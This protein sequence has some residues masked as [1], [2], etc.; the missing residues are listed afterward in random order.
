MSEVTELEIG[1]EVLQNNGGFS[2]TCDVPSSPFGDSDVSSVEGNEETAVMEVEYIRTTKVEQ[3]FGSKAIISLGKQATVGASDVFV[4][5]SHPFHHTSE[6]ASPQAISVNTFKHLE[7]NA[8]ST[9]NSVAGKH[10]GKRSDHQP[11]KQPRSSFALLEERSAGTALRP[12][13]ASLDQDGRS[14][15]RAALMHSLLLSTSV[16]PIS[17]V[18]PVCRSSKESRQGQRYIPVETTFYVD[19]VLNRNEMELLWLGEESMC[20]LYRTE[21]DFDFVWEYASESLRMELRKFSP[22]SSENQ[23]IMQIVRTE[24]IIIGKRFTILRE[25]VR[26]ALGKGFRRPMMKSVIADLRLQQRDSKLKVFPPLKP[27]V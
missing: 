2:L 21:F 8:T 14:T 25:Q 26:L 22:D 12:K 3:S 6:S 23:K 24:D 13:T 18:D 17:S 5:S 9:T 20:C 15:P 11:Q 1:D 19:T 16:P 10:I 7:E 4:G 27:G